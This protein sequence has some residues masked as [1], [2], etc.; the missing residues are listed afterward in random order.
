[1]IIA[2][3]SEASGTG[4][5]TAAGFAIKR[6]HRLGYAA[7]QDAFAW[8]GK[9]VCAD[10]LGIT[11]TRQEKV[12]FIDKLKLH[13][14]VSSSWS[15]NEQSFQAG[16]EFIIGLLGSPGKGNGI[17]GLAP[18]FWTQQI[19]TRAQFATGWTAVSD[20]R[21]KEEAEAVKATGGKV[22]EIVRGKNLGTFNEQRLPPE[23]IDHTIDNNGSVDDLRGAVERYINSIVKG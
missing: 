14:F 19:I 16:R 10:A 20:M 13:G 8:D 9:V 3:Y 5:D 15:G 18:Q 1:M 6:L 2:F 21:Y 7:I 12:A 17:R 11:G 22:V 4:K 23:M